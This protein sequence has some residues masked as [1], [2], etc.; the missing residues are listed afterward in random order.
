MELF[1]QQSPDP[2]V[3]DLVQAGQ[4]RIALFLPQ[5]TKDAVTGEL[6]SVWVD[7][8]RALAARI[9]VKAA[10]LEF[11]NPAKAIECLK[12]GAC[13]AGFLGYDPARAAEVGGFSP[14]F[15]TLDFTYLVPA[16]S[17]IRNA[18]DADRPGIR[19]AAVRNHSSTVVLKS[20]LKHAEM[21]EA[22]TP[23]EAKTLLQ[24]RRAD[25][26]A[27]TRQVLLEYSSQLSGS[28]VL[29]DRFGTNLVRMVVPKGQAG[30]LA[31]ISEFIEDAKSSGLVRRALANSPGIGA[32]PPGDPTPEQ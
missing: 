26:L 8:A 24:T 6:R 32:A 10:L 16:R 12:A 31:Y 9:G 7:V 23:D 14:P 13:D 4:I 15:I 21:V 25:V 18:A 28:R 29:D 22:D 2:R 3:A 30:R 1:S 27:A 11:P 19:I 17:A 20:L 5:Y